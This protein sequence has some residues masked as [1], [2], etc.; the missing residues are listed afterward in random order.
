M[1]D[2][3]RA[4][5]ILITRLSALG[6][7]VLTLP[8]ATAL[9]D[10]FPDAHLAW[11]VEPLSA[12]LIRYHHAVD[13]ALV[14]PKGWL[15]SPRFVFH[16]R[17]RLRAR[18]FQWALDAQ[19][20]TKSA[21]LGWLGGVQRRVGFAR[22]QGREL[23][24]WLDTE[25]IPRNSAHVVQAMLSLLRPFGIVEPRVE[26]GIPGTRASEVATERFLQ[27]AHL[28]RGFAVLNVGASWKSKRWLP[29]RFGRVAR[30]MGEHHDLPSVISWAGAFEQSLAL[31]AQSHSGGHAL[32]APNT[33]LL[34]LVALLRR[35]RLM[36]SSDTGP[37]HLAAAVGTPCIG[38]YGPT[39]YELSGPYG[40]QHI[41]LQ[42][43]CP[44]HRN[45]RRRREDQSAMRVITVDTV[46]QA[47]ADL[48]AAPTAIVP[49]TRFLN[50]A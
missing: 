27:N 41:T 34:Q 15:K 49:S 14:V 48:L 13:E 16:L 4:P 43:E 28:G 8:V 33:T 10:R 6:D 12:D 37:L 9:R 31:R 45:R 3:D 20:L 19:S 11:V 50:A 35:A 42:V 24:P 2:S 47:V 38:L 5:R 22:P 21:V 39:R 32:L 44:F 7:V 36:I 26:F 23:A 30:Y 18:R 25:L 40:P 1:D 17:D 29:Q 46:C